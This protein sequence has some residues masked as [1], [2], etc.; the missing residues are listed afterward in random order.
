VTRGLEGVERV[1]GCSLK[2]GCEVSIY[3]RALDLETY[4]PSVPFQDVSVVCPV[5]PVIKVRLKLTW[6]DRHLPEAEGNGPWLR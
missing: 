2:I 3:A 4:L 5:T 1:C 6:D